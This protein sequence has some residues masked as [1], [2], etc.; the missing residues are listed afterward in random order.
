MPICSFITTYV[1]YLRMI[2]YIHV[3]LLAIFLFTILSTTV[4]SSLVEDCTFVWF[5]FHLSEAVGFIMW[6]CSLLTLYCLPVYSC[7]FLSGEEAVASDE[8]GWEDQRQSRNLPILSEPLLSVSCCVMRGTR[9]CDERDQ[10][11]CDER[12]Q[13]LCDERDQVL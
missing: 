13:V 10:V 12:D 2:V 5:P 8:E 1:I 6:W 3:C 9:C 11:L 7:F 4:G